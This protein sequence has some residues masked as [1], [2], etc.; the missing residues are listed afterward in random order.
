MSKI[1]RFYLIIA[2]LLMS[3]TY[4][5]EAA[6]VLSEYD[7]NGIVSCCGN[8]AGIFPQD[9]LIQKCCGSDYATGDLY[10]MC[11][12]A[13]IKLYDSPYCSAYNP[14]PG[15]PGS[16]SETIICPQNYYLNFSNECIKCPKY[17]STSGI[18]AGSGATSIYQ[19]YIPKNISLYDEYGNYYFV[20]NCYYGSV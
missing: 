17:Q 8:N 15:G 16:G 14:H 11:S 9:E 1:N 3:K 12:D 5:V 19:C 20:N 2:G 7:C 6:P 18:T 10:G 13:C 4:Q